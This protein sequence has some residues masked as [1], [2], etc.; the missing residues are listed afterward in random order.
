[1]KPGDICWEGRHFQICNRLLLDRL[2]EDYDYD[3]DGGGGDVDGDG[4][5]DG[6]G[7]VD[8]DGASGYDRGVGGVESSYPGSTA[9]G[10][11]TANGRPIAIISTS[12]I[13][14]RRYRIYSRKW[15]AWGARTID[16]ALLKIVKIQCQ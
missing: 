1:M 14:V 5:G 16:C 6:D 11:E 7:D 2:N 10:W 15:Q 12:N 8:G 9:G 4:D 13:S 3:D